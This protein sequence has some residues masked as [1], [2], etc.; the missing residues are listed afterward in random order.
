MNGTSSPARYC[1]TLGTFEPYKT[2]FFV[3]YVLDCV[4]NALSSVIATFGNALVIVAVSKTAS[5]HTPQYILLCCLS[6]T[7]FLVGLI[8]QP[9]NI[10]FKV[11]EV[12]SGSFDTY[13]TSGTAFYLVAT[14]LAAV[15]F[16]TITAVSVDRY[17][18]IH[19]H[20][21][22][23]V[24]VTHKRVLLALVGVWSVGIFLMGSWF[25]NISV[26]RQAEIIIIISCL[27]VTSFNY[28][29]IQRVVHRHHTQIRNQIQASASSGNQ[30][31]QICMARYK[32]SVKSM[33]CVYCTVLLC[34]APF[35]CSM[36]VIQVY[37]RNP[38]LHVASN[39]ALTVLLINSSLNPFV[40][41]LKMREIRVAVLQVLREHLVLP[42]WSRN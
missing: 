40:Y 26:C 31:S 27:V 15:S 33:L 23:S 1:K 42:G 28:G 14:C 36:V 3:L 18:A 13:C 22:Y 10:V 20:L 35:L 39:L 30:V 34:Y 25:W 38:V 37:G 16:V 9:L 19:L 6:T 21:R 7:D 8:A 2:D 32:K 29:R 17:L 11:S 41:C 4:L 24:F 12:N 5:L